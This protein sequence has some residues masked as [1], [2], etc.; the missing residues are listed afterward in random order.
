MVQSDA[1]SSL[2]RCVEMSVKIDFATNAS[3][4][5]RIINSV[6]AAGGAPQRDVAG[7]DDEEFQLC[8]RLATSAAQLEAHAQALLRRSEVRSAN[9]NHV[10]ALE[11]AEQA[12]A[13]FPEQ[14]E[15]STL[16]AP[17]SHSAQLTLVSVAVPREGCRSILGLWAHRAGQR[18][19]RPRQGGLG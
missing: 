7:L 6:M 16:T 1:T 2:A 15:V 19:V 9:G 10:G 14:P 3:S 4:S 18:S 11:D 13:L 5:S 17:P 12:M 8:Q